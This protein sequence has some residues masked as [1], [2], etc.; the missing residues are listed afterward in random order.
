MTTTI[1][2]LTKIGCHEAVSITTSGGYE[3]RWFVKDGLRQFEGVRCV[4]G[5]P[6]V[7]DHDRA[8]K[9]LYPPQ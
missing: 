5:V 3:D 4:R 8:R 6:L 2:S 9:L 1:A 7:G